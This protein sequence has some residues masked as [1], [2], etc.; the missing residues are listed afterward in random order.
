[1]LSE[2]LVGRSD[3][4]KFAKDWAQPKEA[5]DAILLAEYGSRPTPG[6][7]SANGRNDGFEVYRKIAAIDCS[8][9]KS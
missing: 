6:V 4:L 1:M 7:I 3:A 2:I 9:F 8:N 5:Y